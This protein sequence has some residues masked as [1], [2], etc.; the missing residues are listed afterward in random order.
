[1]LG[2]AW[3]SAVTIAAVVAAASVAG[4]QT[5][6]LDPA[7]TGA[8]PSL[9]P[10]PFS[11]APPGSVFH[12]AKTKVV[13]GAAD[14][15]F[16]TFTSNGKQYTTS[17][18]ASRDREQ[19]PA[20][21][22]AELAKIWPLSVGKSVRYKR[23]EPR[24]GKRW[25]SDEVSVI[26]TETLK[27]GEKAVDTYVVRWSSRGENGGNTWEGTATTWYAPALGWVVKIQRS[28]SQGIREEDRAV[29]YEL[30]H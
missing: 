10:A 29:S 7:T 13:I 1:M 18:I 30:A 6:A 8:R 4:A 5:S 25:W 28:D 21:S 11:I 26:G 24:G 23:Y 27:I 19:Y 15:Y 9:P 22:I 16:V 12:F 2:R 14:G 17:L 20:E 3:F